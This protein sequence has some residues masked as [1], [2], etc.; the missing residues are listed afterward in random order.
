MATINLGAIKFNWQGAFATGT[1]YKIDDVV[2][3]L[4]SSWVYVNVD[5]K[6]GT[7]AGVPATAN[8]AHWD[9]MADGTSPLT[10]QGDMVTHSGTAVTRLARGAS[11]T[12]LKV[13]GSDLAFAPEE[14]YIGHKHLLSNYGAIPANPSASETYGVSGKYPWLANYTQGWIPECGTPSPACGPIKNSI[15][16]HHINGYQLNAW[17]NENHELVVCGNDDFGWLGTSMG[18][19]HTMGVVNNI[20]QQDG[21][22]RDGDYFVRFWIAYNN[23]MLLTKD[24][25]LFTAG[26]NAY[27]QLGNGKTADS[28]ILTKV[29]T[30][31]PDSTHGGTSTQIAGFVYSNKTDYG[32]AQNTSCYAI[33]TSGRLFTWGYNTAGKLGNGNTTNQTW[34]VH[35][36]GVS[37]IVQ[38]SAGHSSAHCVDSSG[39]LYRTGLNQNG[40]NQGTTVNTWTDTLQDDVYAIENHS[41]HGLAV[42]AASAYYLK[43]NGEMYA[44]GYNHSGNHGNGNSTATASWV[45]TGGT[46]TFSSFYVNGNS[47]YWNMSGLGGT[48][49]SPNTSFYNWGYNPGGQLGVGNATALMTPTQPSTTSKYTFTTT[50]T[51]AGNAP[52]RTMV[53]VPVNGVAH[54]H[55]FYGCVGQGKHGSY[56]EDASGRTWTAGYGQNMD[57]YD[58]ITANAVNYNYYMD[59][60]PWN[61]TK[62]VS[63]GVHWNGKTKVGIHS[64]W[65]TGTGAGSSQGCWMCVTTDGRIWG[66]GYNAQGQMGDGAMIWLGQWSQ[67]TP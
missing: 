21:G 47:L 6:T 7:N 55:P 19:K 57:I 24:G 36:T 42:V 13:S 38:V 32:S 12:V 58:A 10:T 60:A 22:M 25:D 45:R 35:S 17:L 41:G 40:I 31:G 52:T 33:D 8:T 44:I 5:S 30:L 27:G 4:G 39:N 26:D 23:I 61:T 15:R 43:T 50:S 18:N 51:D 49:T 67:L 37:N 11:G 28:Y 9:L 65:M 63:G 56:I 2:S 46:L 64:M 1:T 3:Y 20:S 66:K 14:G 62:T 48:P 59:P 34:P 16:G 53:P 54:V 29:S